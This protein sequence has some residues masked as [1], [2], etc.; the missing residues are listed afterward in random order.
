MRYLSLFSGVEAASVAWKAIG[1][2]C[3]GVAEIEPFPCAILSHHY[4]DVPNLGDV[5]KITEAE[6]AGLGHIDLIVG[7]FPCQDLSVAGKRKG[8]RNADGTVTRSGLFFDAMRL[9]RYA[10]EHCG[11]RFVLI[12][13]VPGLYSSNDGRDFGSLVAEVVGCGFDVPRDG[14]RNSGVACG[15]DGQI[16]WATLDAQWF[17][18]A[19]RRKRVFAL[20]DFGDWAGRAPILLERE[21]LLRNSA[22]RREAGQA[23]TGTLSSRASAGGGLGTDFECS[24]GLIAHALRAEGFDASEDGTGRG[25]PLVPVT[26]YQDSEYGIAGY[27]TAGSL[28]AGREPH[29]QM[30]IQPYTLAIRGRGDSHDLEYR[31]DGTSNA[32]LTP[33]G[34]RGGIGVGA[35]AYA[36]QERAVCENPEAG[37][38]GAGF[39]ADVAYTVEARAV[40]Q[41]V[42]HTLGAHRAGSVTEDG[43]G[44]G[45]PLASS[46]SSVRR[47]TPLEAARLQGFPD[48]YLDI[49]F[50]GKPAADGNKYRALGNSFAVPVVRWIGERIAAEHGRA[51]ADQGSPLMVAAE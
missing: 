51:M 18:L 3:V 36:I 28:R 27:D 21:S 49:Q 30:L 16:E 7:G 25:T 47:I 42:A 43:T 2:R 14:W 50:R 39:R 22:P 4:P 38:D 40:P 6:I 15:P 5:S 41:S 32:L 45:V 19:Q 10:R 11:L 34:G 13:N 33:N 12:E 37:P 35:V 44:W 24:G 31:Q 9:V 23:A 46:G 17:G 26:L 20:G 29:H 8:L 1:W 48:D